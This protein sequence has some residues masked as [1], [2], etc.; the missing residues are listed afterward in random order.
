MWYEFYNN[1]FANMWWWHNVL[2]GMVNDYHKMG[3]CSSH[4]LCDNRQMLVQ[5]D[6]HL[7]AHMHK[8]RIQNTLNW[9]Q[10]TQWLQCI[11]YGYETVTLSAAKT[12]N[13]P[14]HTCVR[15]HITYIHK[16]QKP[17]IRNFI[18]LHNCHQHWLAEI[19]M[20]LDK[21]N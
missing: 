1:I 19:K 4:S 8:Y 6:T 9:K 16:L 18:L 17:R 5:E 21:S 11:I 20:L 2:S 13:Y 12:M 14:T 7:R 3:I 10:S 15:T